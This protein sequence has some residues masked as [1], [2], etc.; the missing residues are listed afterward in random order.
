MDT[1]VASKDDTRGSTEIDDVDDGVT[2]LSSSTRGDA[3]IAMA[4]KWATRRKQQQEEQQQR[5]LQQQEQMELPTQS[6]SQQSR[7]INTENNSNRAMNISEQKRRPSAPSTTPKF[8]LPPLCVLLRRS[9][10]DTV[11]GLKQIQQQPQPVPQKK[12]TSKQQPQ[13]QQE[14]LRRTTF[15]S[16]LSILQANALKLQVASMMAEEEDEEEA[17]Q[18]KQQKVL[19]VL[20]SDFDFISTVNHMSESRSRAFLLLDFSAIV[21]THTVWRKRLPKKKVQMV[22]STKHNANIKLLQLFTRLNVGLRLSTKYDLH[23]VKES[24]C[25]NSG[26]GN[27]SS[28]L[29][30][31]DCSLL[32]KPTSFY[33]SLVLDTATTKKSDDTTINETIPFAVDGSNELDRIHQ[34]LTG[35]VQRR[36]QQQSLPTL[37]VVLKLDGIQPQNWKDVL[38]QLHQRSTELEHNVVG[39]AM[40]LLDENDDNESAPSPLEALSSLIDFANT[41]AILSMPQVHLT[42]PST[43]SDINKDVIQWMENHT[44]VCSQI[45]IDVSRLLVANSGALCARIIGVK[46]NDTSRI[47]YYIDDGCYGSLSNIS[48][49]SIP[50]PLTNQKTVESPQSSL[51]NDQQGLLATVW[52]PTCKSRCCFSGPRFII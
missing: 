45:T 16:V 26:D 7:Q 25:N 24:C 36:K 19:S 9:W 42:N 1:D 30:W 46:Q 14:K 52:G 21:Q 31:D 29:L 11:K 2:S 17:H 38:V 33:R 27:S 23:R 15:P 28:P 47:H 50:L 44:K 41:S 34:Q 22:Y 51:E 49:S 3:R 39:F 8:S 43:S 4:A 6:S 13:Q 10:N 32:A 18:Q 48:N 37:N 20:P 40:E 12:S 5:R 35:I